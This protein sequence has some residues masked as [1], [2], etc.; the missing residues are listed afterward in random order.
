[1]LKQGQSTKKLSA[2]FPREMP[3]CAKRAHFI[4][5]REQNYRAYGRGSG[6]SVAKLVCRAH[7]WLRLRSPQLLCPYENQGDDKLRARVLNP[8]SE[9]GET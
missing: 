4:A 6:A 8:N 3:A 2:R 5:N 9:R 7:H 1:M